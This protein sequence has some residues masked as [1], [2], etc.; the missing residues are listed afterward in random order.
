MVVDELP[1]QKPVSIPAER[2]PVHCRTRMLFG[3][4]E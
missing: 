1:K 4:S 3:V 2:F